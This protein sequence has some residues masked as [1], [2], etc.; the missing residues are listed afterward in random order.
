MAICNIFKQLTKKTGT[1]LTF[2]QYME[3]LTTQQTET[4]FHRVV[5]SKFIALDVQSIKDTF[6]KMLQ[7]GFENACACFKNQSDFTWNPNYSKTLFWNFMFES[8]TITSSQTTQEGRQTIN[9]ILYVGDI[10]LQS[11]N[12]VDGMGYSEIYCHI[13]NDACAHKYEMEY[14]PLSMTTSSKSVKIER[15]KNSTLEGFM[16]GELGSQTVLQQDYQYLLDKDYIFSWNDQTLKTIILDDKSFNINM[17]VILYEVW[18]GDNCVA[19]D[20]PMGIYITGLIDNNSATPIQNS[21]IK[22]VSNDDIYN[23]G[24][25]YGLRICSRYIV[26]SEQDNYIVKEV[27]CEDN[28]YGELCKVLAQLSVS[29][30]K[31]DEIIKKKY[32][33][34]QNYKDLLSIFKNSRTNVPYIKIIDGKKYWFVNGRILDELPNE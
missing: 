19:H 13:P 5:P 4:K 3:D 12:E 31:M 17:I 2:S 22:Y 16:P 9:E 30:M 32:N 33:T 1:F 15:L 25:S 28:N 23:S 27:T 7:D 26:S 29:Q 21:I 24:T 8:G 10:N 11:Y 34:D 18:N 6:P 14:K 20:V